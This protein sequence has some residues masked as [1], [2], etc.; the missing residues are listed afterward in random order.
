MAFG[1]PQSKQQVQWA[2]LR[3]RGN[4]YVCEHN[5]SMLV[6]ETPSGERKVVASHWQGKELNS[7]NDV[8]LRSTIQ[9]F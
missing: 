7:P 8:V 6:M 9:L 4:L 5:T 3:R 1:S 2:Y